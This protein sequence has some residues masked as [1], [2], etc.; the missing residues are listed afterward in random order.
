MFVDDVHWI[1]P[2]SDE[3]LAQSVEAVASAR[4]AVSGPAP[5]QRPPRSSP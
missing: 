1:D 4:T 5:R 3:F 2:G